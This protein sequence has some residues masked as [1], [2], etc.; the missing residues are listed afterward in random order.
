MVK[1]RK[2]PARRKQPSDDGV[3]RILVVEDDLDLGETV[4]EILK[5]SGYRA[6][7]ATDGLVALQML[8]QGGLYDLILLDLMMPR[9]DG[10][11]FRQAQLRDKKFKNIP[12]VV[13]SAVG[14][15]SRPIKAD[16]LLRKPVE[17]DELL[18]TVK[19]FTVRRS[20]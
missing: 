13:L 3:A 16:E 2:N 9:M 15:I 1:G 19:K 8:G 12:V 17:P 5:M 4:C 7:H 18:E 11:A 14:E 10:W 6:S 20:G